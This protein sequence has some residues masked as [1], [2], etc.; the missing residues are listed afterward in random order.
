MLHVCVPRVKL[1]RVLGERVDRFLSRLRPIILARGVLQRKDG[2]ACLGSGNSVLDLA[3]GGATIAHSISA[4]TFPC[5]LEKQPSIALVLSP[6]PRLDLPVPTAFVRNSKPAF[7]TQPLPPPGARG[8]FPTAPRPRPTAPH[9]H[10]AVRQNGQHQE[11]EGTEYLQ[12]SCPLTEMYGVMF[13]VPSALLFWRVPL[14]KGADGSIVLQ[15]GQI[16]SEKTSL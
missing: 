11:E 6:Q 8:T 10:A 13:D 16:I 7:V 5:S 3:R 9:P 12:F 15:G 4:A 2:R 14:R 1:C